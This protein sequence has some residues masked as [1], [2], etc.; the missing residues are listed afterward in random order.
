MSRHVASAEPTFKIIDAARAIVTRGFR[1]LPV[2]SGGK[3]VGIVTS[4]DILRYLGSSKLFER[5]GSDRFDD[6]MSVGVQEIMTKDVF[7]VT[8]ETDIGEA[9]ALM[10]ERDCGGLPVVSEDELVGIITEHDL[11][12]LL[13]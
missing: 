2:V 5:M 3:L 11:M 9:A 10:R 4:M 6:A 13:V 12:R 1:R 7:K 8:P